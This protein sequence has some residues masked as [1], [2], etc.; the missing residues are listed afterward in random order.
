MY[1]NELN[2]ESISMLLQYTITII[3]ETNLKVFSVDKGHLVTDD[4]VVQSNSSSHR[5]FFKNI[6][7]NARVNLVKSG[8]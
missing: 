2:F 5:F 7:W 3:Q 1:V 6:L 4:L 8:S